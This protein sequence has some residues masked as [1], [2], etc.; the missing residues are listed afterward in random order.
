MDMTEQKLCRKCNE[1]KPLEG[2]FYKAGKS[3]QKY[4]IPCH[5]AKRNDYANNYKYEK[6]PKGFLKLPEDIRNKILHD[7]SIR[8]NFK[9][10]AE[11][12]GVK[13][14]TILSWKRKGHLI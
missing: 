2:G 13:Y 4:C 12:Y 1:I 5:N 3:Y 6:I 7:I 10:I 8:I 9:E 11:K 14:N